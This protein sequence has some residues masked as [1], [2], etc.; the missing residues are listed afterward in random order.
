MELPA[1]R[2]LFPL[3]QGIVGIDDRIEKIHCSSPSSP[4]FSSKVCLIKGSAAR[5]TSMV[6][7]GLLTFMLSLH[8]VLFCLDG[9]VGSMFHNS[10]PTKFLHHSPFRRLNDNEIAVLEPAGMFKKLPNLKKMYVFFLHSFIHYFMH[11]LT[12]FIR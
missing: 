4:L 8:L 12:Q 6:T 7:K 5:H 1:S 9:P 11:L 3:A 2:A 10:C